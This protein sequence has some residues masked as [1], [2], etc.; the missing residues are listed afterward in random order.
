MAFQQELEV[1][2]GDS[3]PLSHINVA[4]FVGRYPAVRKRHALTLLTSR[5][6]PRVIF[7]DYFAVTTITRRLRHKSS[8]QAHELRGGIY[9]LLWKENGDRPWSDKPA[10]VSLAE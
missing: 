8:P 2:R 1:F 10:P 7:I 4:L 3:I 6:E 5:L 9:Y